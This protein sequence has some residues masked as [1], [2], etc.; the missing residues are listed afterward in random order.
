MLSQ[1]GS[2]RGFIGVVDTA[3]AVNFEHLF[4]T[5]QRLQGRQRLWRKG[6]HIAT[7]RQPALSVEGKGIGR[8]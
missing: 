1:G 5:A 3:D 4:V 6:A 8:S 7:M 2:N